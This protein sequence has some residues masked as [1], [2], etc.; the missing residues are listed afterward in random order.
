MNKCVLQ[1]IFI[2]ADKNTLAAAWR[3]GH[4]RGDLAVD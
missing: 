1:H 4:V 2:H 3:A